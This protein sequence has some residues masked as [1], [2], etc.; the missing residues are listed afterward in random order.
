MKNFFTVLGGMSTLA[1]QGY[2][3]LVNH[4]VKIKDDQDYMNYILVNH[5]TI[6]DRTTWIE[7][8]SKPNPYDYF[9]R[10]RL[11]TSA[12]ETRFFPYAM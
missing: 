8:H 5:A 9:K 4:R 6:P 10:R 3:N 12:I 1:T 2:I 7:D 11:T